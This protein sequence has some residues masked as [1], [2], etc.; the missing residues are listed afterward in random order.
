MRKIYTIVL[1]CSI[2]VAAMAKQT[3]TLVIPKLAPGTALT[4]DGRA[5]EAF[6]ATV[7]NQAISKLSSSKPA[8]LNEAYFKMAY[9]D[10]M[11]LLYLY[12]N[13]KSTTEPAFCNKYCTKLDDW[14]SDRP[15]IYFNANP[16]TDLSKTPGAMTPNVGVTQFT[17]TFGFLG[18]TSAAFVGYNASYYYMAN[19]IDG[20]TYT[21]EFGFLFY[22]SNTETGL[23]DSLGNAL[24]NTVGTQFGF[25]A[26]I[27]DRDPGDPTE[28][29]ERKWAYWH[30]GTGDA[31][32]SL[33]GAGVIEL[34]TVGGV[35]VKEVSMPDIMVTP[36]PASSILQISAIADKVEVYNIFGQMVSKSSLKNSSMNVSGYS[37]GI[38]FIKIY[39]NG[40]LVGKSKFIKQ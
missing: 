12:V 4:F 10:S 19:H 37:S 5:S 3:P 30:D 18:D 38:Y 32:N 26:Y 23:V 11:I 22:D 34:G 20:N 14:K 29:T 36:N 15:E 7:D 1:L 28:D 21:Y 33:K 31:W 24:S 8:T 6:W 27:L 35:G 25:D 40:T 9:N 16:L 2:A 13:D 39:S 17:G